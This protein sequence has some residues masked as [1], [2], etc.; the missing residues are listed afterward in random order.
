MCMVP[1]MAAGSDGAGGFGLRGRGCG[2]PVCGQQLAQVVLVGHRREAFEHV[3]QIRFHGVSAATGAFHQRVDDGGALAGGFAAGEEPVLFTNG[4]GP[5]AV[6]DPVVVNFQAAVLLIGAEL[7][8]LTEGVVDGGSQGTSGEDFGALAQGDELVLEDLELRGGAFAPEAGTLCGGGPGLAEARLDVI[9]LLDAGK[10]SGSKSLSGF[11]RFMELAPGVRPTGDEV[12][13]CF[14]RSPGVVSGVGVGLEEALVVSKQVVEAAGPATGMPLVEDVAFATVARGVQDPEVSGGAFPSA[15]IE[16]S[17]G[18]FVGLQVVA[19]EQFLVD[20]FV[21]RF[22]GVGDDAVPVTEGV[23]GDLNSVALAQDALA[24]VVGPVMAVLGGHHVGDEPG[25]GGE[26][27]RGRR[28]DL[29]RNSIGLADGDVDDAHETLDEDAW[30]LVVEPVG[31]DAVELAVAFRVGQDFVGNENGLAHFEVR[32][33]AGLAGGALLDGGW[34]SRRSWVCGNGGV[35]F[36][37]GVGIQQEFE[38]GGVERLAFRPEEAAEQCVD[39]RFEQ[40]DAL[41]V[42]RDLVAQEGVFIKQLLLALRC[43]LLPA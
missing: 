12:D 20:E 25:G 42:L 41:T 18:G 36:F 11:K 13:A 8:P 43:H 22:E 14:S 21:E 32:E 9:K 27:E 28:G 31:D 19:L 7:V 26:S 29:D 10:R 34:L 23:A 5:N 17:N 40:G 2:L 3:G 15:G 30:G 24:A 37:C 38:L 35:G 6:L 39:L 4:G 33:V 16:V 1:L